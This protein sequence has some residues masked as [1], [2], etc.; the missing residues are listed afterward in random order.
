[1]SR[2]FLLQLLYFQL[3]LPTEFCIQNFLFVC[4]ALRGNPSFYSCCMLGVGPVILTIKIEAEYHMAK[5][6]NNSNTTD[7]Q[8]P[9][10]EHLFRDHQTQ[11]KLSHK[12]Y[13]CFQ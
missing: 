4:R 10:A 12:Q 1:M 11:A 7:V 8:R 5:G 6:P 13:F 3:R 2:R 9:Y